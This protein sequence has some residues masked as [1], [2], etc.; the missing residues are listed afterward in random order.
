MVI[1]KIMGGLASQIH[2]F[3]LGMRFSRE[4]D[5]ELVLDLSDY[6][7]GYFRPYRLSEFALPKL[8]SIRTREIEKSVDRLIYLNTSGDIENMLRNPDKTK[9][10]YFWKEETDFGDFFTKNSEYE[11]SCSSYGLEYFLPPLDNSFLN[12]FKNHISGRKTV[13]VHVRRG[14]FV[15][16][17]WES[18]DGYYQ[19]AMEYVKDIYPDALFCFFSNDMNW[20]R[21]NFGE[22]DNHYFVSSPDIKNAD[23]DELWAMA[24]TDVRI[25]SPHSGYGLVANVIAGRINKDSFAISPETE[26]DHYEYRDIEGRIRYI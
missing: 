14:D 20:T 19:R 5:T 12:E 24:M 25:L 13:A 10:Y 26:T 9:N 11:M 16:L 8:K 23:I 2:K 15:T 18:E 6:Y 1:I 3:I 7:E 21:E 17:G 4:L 22:K